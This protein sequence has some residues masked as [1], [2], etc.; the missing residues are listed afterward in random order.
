MQANEYV[1]MQLHKLREVEARANLHV[2]PAVA[3]AIL[4][5]KREILRLRKIRRA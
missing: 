5:E 1:V 3:E 4:L 2:T